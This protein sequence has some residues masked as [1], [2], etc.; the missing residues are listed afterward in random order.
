[1]LFW[2]VYIEK[3][4]WIKKPRHIFVLTVDVFIQTRATQWEQSKS[5]ST[6][7]TNKAG[8]IRWLDEISAGMHLRAQAESNLRCI[9]TRWLC[10]V[11][12]DFSFCPLLFVCLTHPWS[13]TVT[14]SLAASGSFLSSA[15]SRVAWTSAGLAYRK[16]RWLLI[17]AEFWNIFRRLMRILSIKARPNLCHHDGELGEAGPLSW[18]DG[19]ALPHDAIHLLRAIRRFLQPLSLPLHT[20]QDLTVGRVNWCETKTLSHSDS[21]RA[22]KKTFQT[23]KKKKIWQ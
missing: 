21:V 4:Q 9:S 8:C 10:Y 13:T 1:M 17:G 22:E 12:A 6:R 19:P 5:C 7:S 18:C 23:F 2:L 20:P 15:K 16:R 14:M 11:S 3:S